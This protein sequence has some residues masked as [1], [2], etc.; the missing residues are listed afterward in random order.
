MTIEKL[1]QAAKGP[2]TSTERAFL[3]LALLL[4]RIQGTKSEAS[5]PSPSVARRA[6]GTPAAPALARRVA[7]VRRPEREQFKIYKKWIEAPAFAGAGFLL[8]SL[9]LL[10][11]KARFE[12]LATTYSPT[13]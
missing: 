2:V 5:R 7:Q 4:P 12:G 3:T 1:R 8:N 6:L 9:R 13:P 10:N 11:K